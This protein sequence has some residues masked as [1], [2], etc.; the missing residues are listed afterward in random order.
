MPGITDLSRGFLVRRIVRGALALALAA[1]ALSLV[2]V[3]PAS[4]AVTPAWGYV[5]SNHPFDQHSTPIRAWQKNSQGFVN[6]VTRL[7][8]GVYVVHFTGLEGMG[9]NGG[10]VYVTVG[11]SFVEQCKVG[12][13]TQAASSV[14]VTVR[15]FTRDGTPQDAQFEAA[16]IDPGST[17]PSHLGYVW[18]NQPTA[19][20]YT[21]DANYQFNARDPGVAA[22]TIVRNGVGNY[23]VNMP[24]IGASHSTVKVTAYGG[25][26]TQCQS[27]GWGGSGLVKANVLCHDVFGTPVDA[28]FTLAYTVKSSMLGVDGR[29][30][31]Y[32]WAN[33]PTAP[34]Y[35][36]N[37]KF[38]W[39][40]ATNAPDITVNRLGTGV[41][42]VV[43]QGLGPPGGT[44]QPGGNIQVTGWGP[45]VAQCNT[46]L[47]EAFAPNELDVD[48]YCIDQ[49]G[50]P[51]DAFF[52]VQYMK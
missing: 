25:D 18:A 22:N 40:S 43:M 11:Q 21:P 20:S 33:A 17:P 1:T 35:T 34:S 36:P 50:N 14:D 27:N 7:S 12:S 28:M 52:V 8:T 13:W 46:D 24:F 49:G 5:L 41:Y 51:I 6:K 47:G 29:K 26:S 19:A 44:F 15:C 16:Y 39:D 3:A 30:Y 37:P 23:T 31:G 4:A 45:S 32:A 38:Q 9:V 2:G 48:V 42:T 10:T